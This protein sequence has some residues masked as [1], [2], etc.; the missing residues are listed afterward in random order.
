MKSLLLRILPVPILFTL[1]FSTAFTQP[2]STPWQAKVDPWVLSSAGAGKIE[3][4]VFLEQQAD[5]SGAEELD[6]KSQKGAYV[7]DQ[8]GK[9]AGQT[10]QALLALLESRGLQH[11]SFWIANMILVKAD[12]QFIQIL[13]ERDDVAHIYANPQVRLDVQPIEPDQDATA[14]LEAEQS[15]EWNIALVGAPTVWQEGY[16]GQGVVI[17]GQDTG[18]EW[19]H[20]ALKSKYRGWDGAAVDH[21]YNWHDAIHETGSDCGADA[22]EPC[23]DWGHGTHTMG[24]MVGDDGDGYQI[25][26]APGARWIGCRNMNEGV[27]SPATYSE[28]YEW[29]LAP[30]DLDG[31]NPRPDLAP[32]VINNSWT[33]PPK[34][35]CDDPGVLLTVVQNLRAAGIVTVHAAGNDGSGCRTVNTPASIYAESFTVGATDD[36]DNIAG[37]SSRGPVS[38]DGSFR[39]K[40]D[41][42]A[43]GVGIT[44]SLLNGSYGWNSGTSMAAP[45]V[46]GLVALLISADPA[47]RGQ[48]DEIEQIIRR[49]AQPRTSEQG[50]GDLPGDAVPN[51]T[52]GWGRV[53]AERAYWFA[54]AEFLYLPVMQREK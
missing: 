9:T 39:L 22:V 26:M 14:N 43:P 13:A 32:D 40:P 36:E 46:A 19:E 44:S 37:F 38:I 42:S 25:G 34:E 5:L 16:T 12:L 3:F 7:F 31:E 21:N 10:Q 51:H 1:V 48:V 54:T 52:Y 28:C 27:G 23:D 45:H 15:V 29:F 50:C 4:L 53:D 8:L 18:Y 11:R 6:S 49:T 33:C 2:A 17:A 24:T 35:G 41:I 20:Q 47:L 30:T